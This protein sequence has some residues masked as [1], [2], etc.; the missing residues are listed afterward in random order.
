MIE[1]E[2]SPTPPL[3]LFPGTARLDVARATYEQR[4]KTWEQ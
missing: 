1:K 2:D 3:R 4:F